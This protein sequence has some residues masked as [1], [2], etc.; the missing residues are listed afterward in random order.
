MES[1][2]VLGGGSRNKLLT[3]LTAERTGLQVDDGEPESSTIGNFAVQ[4]AAE[5]AG[6]KTIEQEK[7]RQWAALLCGK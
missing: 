1:I 6:G 4:L 3:E 5:E 2:H 7:L